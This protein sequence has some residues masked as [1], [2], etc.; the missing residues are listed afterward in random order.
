MRDAEIQRLI[1]Q[2][3]DSPWQMDFESFMGNE[4]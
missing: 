2:R 1:Q 4:A 3:L